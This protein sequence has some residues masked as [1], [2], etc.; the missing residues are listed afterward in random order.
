[1]KNLKEIFASVETFVMFMI[2]TA[3]QAGRDGRDEAG[4][5]LRGAA[6]A[7]RAMAPLE[8][9]PLINTWLNETMTKIYPNWEWR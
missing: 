8:D 7:I 4:S 3:E 6:Y 1:M 5:F 2:V 9:L